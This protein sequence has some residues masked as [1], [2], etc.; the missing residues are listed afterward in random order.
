MPS[1]LVSSHCLGGRDTIPES[2]H[3]LGGRDT[4]PVSS[5]CL[6][7]RNTI[8]V[9]SEGAFCANISG[10]VVENAYE[11]LADV[12]KGCFQP[13]FYRDVVTATTQSSKVSQNRLFDMSRDPQTAEMTTY[14]NILSIFN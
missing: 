10:D 4:A 6:G 2:S 3:C 1:R 7:G 8:P 9:S 5:H 12:S 14:P 13:T 11:E